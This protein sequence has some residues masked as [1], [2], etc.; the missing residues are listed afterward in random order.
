MSEKTRRSVMRPFI[1]FSVILFFIIF[2]AGCTAFFFAMHQIIRTN[3]EAKLSQLVEIKRMNLENSV[4]N[5]IHIVMKMAHSPLIKSYFTNPNDSKLKEIALK[6][7]ADYRSAFS[8]NSVFWVNDNDKKF[9]SDNSDSVSTYLLDPQN[10]DSYWYNMT[11][12]ET[13]KYNFNINYNP[14]LKVTNLWINA[15]VFDETDKPIGM[16]GTGINLSAFIDTTYKNYNEK[17]NLYFFNGLGEIT[18]AKDTELAAVKKSI[19]EEMDKAKSDI[20]SIA[21]TLVPNEIR[22]INIPQGQLA[23]GS[24]QTLGWYAAAFSPLTIDDYNNAVTTLFLI[25][26]VVIALL[27]V[28]F[29][30]FIA[31]NLKKL[32]NTMVDLEIASSSKSEFLATMS[33]E[34][35][36]PMNA[37]IGITHIQRQKDNLPGE[38]ADAFDKIYNSGNNLLGIINDILDMSNIESNELK[39]SPAEYSL[40]S[41]INDAVMLNISRIDEKP[42]EFLLDLNENLPSKMVGDDLRLRQILN[43]LLSNAVKYTKSGFIKLAIDHT[44]NGSEIDLRFRVSD[45][46]LGIKDNSLQKMLSEEQR[47]NSKANRT[48][49]GAG[50][51]LNITKKLVQMMDGKIE[52]QSEYGKGSTFAVTVRQRGVKCES[53]GSELSQKL[54]NFNYTA[55]KQSAEQKLTYEQMPYGK[56][57]VVDDVEINL[58]V[59]EGLLT[60][61]QLKVDTADSG[62]AALD[63]IKSG[64]VYDV[65]FMDHMMPKMDG[66]ETTKKIRES[67]YKGAIVALTANALAGN[68]E[69][70]LKNGFDGFISKPVDI[71]FLDATL[72][73]FVQGKHPQEAQKIKECGAEAAVTPPPQP[74][75]QIKPVKGLVMSPRL[76]EIFCRDAKKTVVNMRET[77][78]NGD[79]KLFTTTV[80]G[81]KAALA[82]IGES[83]SSSL[84]FELEKAG[85][86]G[87]IEF[88]NSNMELLI[89][90]LENIVLKLSPVKQNNTGESDSDIQEDSACLKEQLQLI[91]SACENYDDTAAYALLDNL[92]EKSWKA[93][94]KSALEEIREMLFL[95]SDFDGAAA[96]ASKMLEVNS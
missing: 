45:S 24:V 47:F 2:T 79:I 39:L 28:I 58:F 67:G 63:K 83:E 73:K 44:V 27:F 62:F 51:G 20:V 7:I 4:N 94:T 16:L 43:N 75:K 49:E 85:Q 5:E 40:P 25:A 72:H 22:I 82:H 41:L 23:V 11:L 18:G 8:S 48:A 1:I 38:Y 32:N 46:G 66:I 70:F 29:N 12:Y 21:K 53:I 86:S 10:P 6:E 3:K 17:F 68:N 96:K 31:K 42:I 91:K 71:R 74:A 55:K 50:F 88:I 57:L 93:Q 78:K 65:I 13:E 81:I 59:A 14:E 60:P 84:A 89:E 35:R 87:N 90:K 33:H 37:I 54:R 19:N 92:K 77:V 15:P 95:H 61:Y 34:I 80:H 56:V 26:A 36:T 76:I 64:E 52:A 30:M 69:M 9:Y